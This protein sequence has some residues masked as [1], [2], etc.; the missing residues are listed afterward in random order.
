M[1]DDDS[2]FFLDG[3]CVQPGLETSRSMF[4]SVK[5]VSWPQYRE[6]PKGGRVAHGFNLSVLTVNRHILGAAVMV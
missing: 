3:S 1:I 2:F 5:S 6:R 4:L